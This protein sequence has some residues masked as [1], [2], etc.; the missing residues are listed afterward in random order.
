MEITTEL[1]CASCS[2]W[3]DQ[4]CLLALPFAKHKAVDQQQT[5]CFALH[6]GQSKGEGLLSH[7]RRLVD[8]YLCEAVAGT[9]KH[10]RYLTSDGHVVLL[11]LFLRIQNCLSVYQIPSGNPDLLVTE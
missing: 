3:S 2:D 11:H 6:E 8:H 9:A 1:L 7:W 4:G 10:A 5:S